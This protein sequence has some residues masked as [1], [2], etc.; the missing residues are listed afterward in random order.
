LSSL[1]MRGPFVDL[2][3]DHDKLAIDRGQASGSG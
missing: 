3:E 2:P 1:P